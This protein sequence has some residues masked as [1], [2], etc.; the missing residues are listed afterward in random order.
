MK[1][2]PPA[3]RIN[4]SFMSMRSPG[5]QGLTVFTRSSWSETRLC[6]VPS[7]ANWNLQSGNVEPSVE[8]VVRPR[9]GQRIRHGLAAAVRMLPLF[10]RSLLPIRQLEERA[11]ALPDHRLRCITRTKATPA[12]LASMPSSSSCILAWPYRGT[13]LPRKIDRGVTTAT[14]GIALV[15]LAPR[16]AGFTQRGKRL[17]RPA[18][19]WHERKPNSLTWLDRNN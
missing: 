15:R 12:R 6:C 10:E 3:T 5:G 18:V 11:T 7:V 13:R 19:P 9:I 4:L 17:P 14:T 2:P 1:P 8:K 16:R